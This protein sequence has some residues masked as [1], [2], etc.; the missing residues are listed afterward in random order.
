M[1][2]PLSLTIIPIAQFLQS[3]YFDAL[4]GTTPDQVHHPGLHPPLQHWHNLPPPVSPVEPT[5][6]QPAA[7]PPIASGSLQG[8]LAVPVFNGATM[9]ILV[10]NIADGGILARF[11]NHRQPDLANV[12][13]CFLPMGMVAVLNDVVRIFPM[14]QCVV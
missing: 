14:V 7:A 5:A 6:V 2:K 10:Y 1:S 3:T 11:P 4:H 9:D 8:R 12:V 13:A